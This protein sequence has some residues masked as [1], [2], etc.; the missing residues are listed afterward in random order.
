MAGTARLQDLPPEGGYKPFNYNRVPLRPFLNAKLLIGGYIGVSAAAM[1]V[2]HLSAKE[3]T[4]DAIEMR[5]SRNVIF[6]VL[7]AE[8]DREYLKQ[9]R[10]NRDDE[11][12]LMKNVPGWK[13]G[14]WFG[15]P[16]YKTR[17]N[18]EWHDP[19]IQDFY[20]HCATKYF[21]QRVYQKHWT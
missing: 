18:D 16:I 2:Y 19:I 5:S 14:T 21:L 4:R 6:P 17:P 11:A 15:E 1:Y 8:R 10:R 20:G 3:M 7:L 12:E 9:V 13:V